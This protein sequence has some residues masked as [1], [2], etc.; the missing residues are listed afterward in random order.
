MLIII[1]IKWEANFIFKSINDNIQL[2]F[3]YFNEA[4]PAQVFIS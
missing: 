4:Q 2:N 3:I 1:K